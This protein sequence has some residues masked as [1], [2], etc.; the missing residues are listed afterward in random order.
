MVS[1]NRWNHVLKSLAENGINFYELIDQISDLMDT[2]SFF[3]EDDLKAY[4]LF[5]GGEKFMEILFLGDQYLLVKFVEMQLVDISIMIFL[6]MT[7]RI[8]RKCTS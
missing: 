5:N 6:S 8:I 2:Q 4:I 1:L 7:M 3:T